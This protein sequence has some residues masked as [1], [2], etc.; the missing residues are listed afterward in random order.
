[1]REFA[2]PAGAPLRPR[3]PL[4]HEHHLTVSR[5]EDLPQMAPLICCTRLTAMGSLID[6]AYR[7]LA[8]AVRPALNLSSRRLPD[9]P[10]SRSRDAVRIAVRLNASLGRSE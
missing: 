3:K 4:A 1:M 2:H 9:E 6:A 10:Y 5:Q 7:R 8:M